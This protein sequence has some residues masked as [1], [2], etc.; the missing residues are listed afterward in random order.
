[1][2]TKILSKLKKYWIVIL[3]VVVIAPALAFAADYALDTFRV[4]NTQI[5]TISK[6]GRTITLDGTKGDGYDHLVPT[7]TE[8]GFLSFIN[9][10]IGQLISGSCSSDCT[11]KAC[12][13]LNGCGEKCINQTCGAGYT[14]SEVGVCTATNTCGTKNCGLDSSGNV[15]GTCAVNSYCNNGYCQACSCGSSNC[16]NNQCGQSC[17]SCTSP[18]ECVLNTGG[19]LN[20]V[21]CTPKC[22][23]T[24]CG[25]D[26]CGGYCGC[27]EKEA[28]SGGKCVPCTPKCDGK[29]CGDDGCGGSCGSCDTKAG[30]SCIN[31]SCQACTPKAC[32]GKVCGDDGC[33]GTCSCGKEKICGADSQCYDCDPVA[34]C[35]GKADC[36][37]DGCGGTCG[38]KTCDAGQVCNVFA[39]CQECTCDEKECGDDGCGNPCGSCDPAE[40]ICSSPWGEE[41]MKYRCVECPD[42]GLKCGYSECG[43]YYGPCGT[44]ENCVNG[45]C[46]AI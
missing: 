1:M 10:R 23:G 27:R 31:Y 39:G 28:C 33:G 14:C 32:D 44:K 12:G 40:Q 34:N 3:I 35:D 38:G 42:E 46:K 37:P 6:F 2:L 20:C 5:S 45:E 17:G 7:K 21:A 11:G 4:Y 26:G 30:E 16:G 9:S 43:R 25:S 19:Y 18:M 36:A 15:C 41:Y 29:K 22:D 13:A 8:E 24:T